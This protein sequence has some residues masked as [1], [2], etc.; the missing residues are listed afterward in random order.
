VPA[1][2]PAQAAHFPERYG[3]KP[4]ERNGHAKLADAAVVEIRERYAAGGISQQA[5]A[6]E[7]GVHQGTISKVVLGLGWRHVA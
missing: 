4:G 5:L 3:G 2:T 7:F 6:D 1:L